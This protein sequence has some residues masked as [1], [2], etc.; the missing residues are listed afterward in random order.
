MM[1]DDIKKALVEVDLIIEQVIPKE[2]TLKI[3]KK[4]KD[5][6]K[7]NKDPNYLFKYN[8]EKELEEQV[9]MND[10]K[11]LLGML[12]L[13]YWATD[14]EKK[15]INHILDENEKKYIEQIS[16]KYSTNNIF[17]KQEKKYGEEMAEINLPVKHKEGMI[18]KIIKFIKSIFKRS[19]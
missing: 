15:E 17:K 12:Y 7:N 10:T 8:F 9:L 19:D 2:Q 13:N 3:P 16:E 5:F 4:F 1:S 14:D 6:I 18:K 11:I